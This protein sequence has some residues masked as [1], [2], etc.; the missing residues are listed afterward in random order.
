MYSKLSVLIFIALLAPTNPPTLALFMITW[1][2]RKFAPERV[3]VPDPKKVKVSTLIEEPEVNWA[4]ALPA[5]LKVRFPVK[6]AVE[7]KVKNAPVNIVFVPITTLPPMV[8][9]CRNSRFLS[10]V[11]VEFDIMLNMLAT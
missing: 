4:L 10:I 11:K 5:S 2:A 6:A 9:V 1:A 7:V 3:R 8:A